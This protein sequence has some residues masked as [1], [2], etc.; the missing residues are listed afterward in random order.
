MTRMNGIL[1]AIAV[2]ALAAWYFTSGG[3]NNAVA[4][5]T[6]FEFTE[7]AS[8]FGLKEMT[9][10]NPDAPVTVVEYASYTC[11]HCGRFHTGAFKQLK[12]DFIDTG[13]INFVYREVYFDRPGLWASMVA[14]CGDGEKFHGITDL[15]Y[16]DQAGWARAGDPA[17]IVRELGKI[18]RL[19]GLDGDTLDACLQDSEKAENLNTWQ[20]KNLAADGIDSTPSFVINGKKYTNMAY[21]EMKGLIDAA[22][23]N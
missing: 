18:G 7:T 19:A 2:V 8:E 17:A 23:G 5:G 14:R 15:I 10:G 9:Q 6:S 4:A 1:A 22:L 12:A 11:P 20:T 13:K 21:D 3:N 16:K